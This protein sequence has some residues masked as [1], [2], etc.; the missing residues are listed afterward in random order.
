M[1]GGL[2]AT[3]SHRHLKKNVFFVL[4][5]PKINIANKNSRSNFELYRLNFLYTI[6]Y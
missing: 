1:L 5:G 2:D 6:V 4:G 3:A